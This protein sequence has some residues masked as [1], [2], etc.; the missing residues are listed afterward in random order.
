[1]NTHSPAIALVLLWTVIAP[2]GRS[3]APRT[4]SSV[5]ARATERLPVPPY[6]ARYGRSRPVIAVLGDNA[7][8]ETT[9]YVV[10][11]GILAESGVA[12]VVA[13]STGPGPIQMRPA[14]RFQ[15]HATI[16]EFDARV[17]N[18]AD[19]VVV[20]NIYGAAEKREVLDWVRKQ[21]RLGATIVGICDGVPVLANAGLLEGRRATAHWRTIGRLE[22][23]NRRTTWVRNQRYVADGNVIT[24]SGVSA[25][26]PISVAL[27]QAIGG[28][29]AAERLAHRL[30]VTDW[31]PTHNS[32]QFFLGARLFTALLNAA[33]FWRHEELG[34][35]VSPGVDEISLALT[36][37]LYSRTRRSWAYAVARSSEPV[38][39]RRGLMVL[40]DRVAGVDGIDVMLDTSHGIPP[41]RALERSLA[42]IGDR[43]G[44]RTEAFVAV[45]IE[46]PGA[47]E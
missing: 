32:D 19:Y 5:D 28:R 47:R 7:A 15:V 9:D 31:T 17:P 1:M 22:K 33:A 38:P 11:Y 39:T 43:Y 40:P 3:S 23:E 45:Q 35:E 16:A 24:T 18:G 41:A 34:V 21:S 12:D 25:S 6:Q 44:K 29:E 42:G 20:P 13:L 37:D 36:A 27:V 46:Y 4:T 8:T 2:A 14:L 10:P 26:I 30:G